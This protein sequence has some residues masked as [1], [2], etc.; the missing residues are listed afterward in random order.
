MDSNHHVASRSPPTKRSTQALSSSSKRLHSPTEISSEEPSSKKSK[1]A[2]DG[3]TSSSSNKQ[4]TRWTPSYWICENCGK[5]GH[6]KTECRGAYNPAAAELVAAEKKQIC[7][8]CGKRGHSWEVCRSAY[9]PAA[10]DI[11]A[12]EKSR[13]ERVRRR[14]EQARFLEA[15]HPPLPAQ[16]PAHP[17][18]VHRPQAPQDPA[19]NPVAA[20]VTKF[21][22]DPAV[23][24]SSCTN[25]FSLQPKRRAENVC[26]KMASRA[27]AQ[28]SSGVSSTGENDLDK[29][30]TAGTSGDFFLS[31]STHDAH[32]RVAGW[33]QKNDASTTCVQPADTGM[34]TCTQAASQPV[35]QSVP[36]SSNQVGKTRS[37]LIFPNQINKSQSEAA[38]YQI[39]KANNQHDDL[40]EQNKSLISRVIT[41]CETVHT[42]R[43]EKAALRSNFDAGNVLLEGIC[44]T[45]KQLEALLT[46]AQQA[47][48]AGQGLNALDNTGTHRH[49]AERDSDSKLSA[50]CAPS[51]D[52]ITESIGEKRDVDLD[53][54]DQL[55][56][57]Q[58]AQSHAFRPDSQQADDSDVQE[59][60]D[61]LRATSTTEAVDML[62]ATSTTSLCELHELPEDLRQECDCE[63]SDVCH[64]RGTKHLVD[65]SSGCQVAERCTNNQNA[66][67]QFGM[68][69]RVCLE[70]LHAIGAGKAAKKPNARKEAE[71]AP[72]AR[73]LCDSKL[74]DPKLCECENG[75]KSLLPSSGAS[76]QGCDGVELLTQARSGS[77]QQEHDVDVLYSAQPSTSMHALA[78]NKEQTHKNVQK[79]KEQST[80]HKS[81]TTVRECDITL[82]SRNDCHAGNEAHATDEG[83]NTK[84]MSTLRVF[85]HDYDGSRGLRQADMQHDGGQGRGQIRVHGESQQL[86]SL[87]QQLESLKNER[88]HE[89]SALCAEIRDTKSA[90]QK[91]LAD[92]DSEISEMRKLNRTMIDILKKKDST[93]AARDGEILVLQQ[94]LVDMQGQTEH[95]VGTRNTE[96]ATLQQT[97]EDLQNRHKREIS[98]KDDEIATL[99]QSV[100]HTGQHSEHAHAMVQKKKYYKNELR[101]VRTELQDL[102]DT[103]RGLEGEICAL[104]RERDGLKA[105]TLLQDRLAKFDEQLTRMQDDVIAKKSLEAEVCALN[106]ERDALK[107]KNSDLKGRL[108]ASVKACSTLTED[109]ARL[110]ARLQQ[111]F[112]HLDEFSNDLDTF[113]EQS[114]SQLTAKDAEI[115]ALKDELRSAEALS[116]S[117]VGEYES[118]LGLLENKSRQLGQDLAA[119]KRELEVVGGKYAQICGAFGEFRSSLGDLYA[120]VMTPTCVCMSALVYVYVYVYTYAYAY[121]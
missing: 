34:L 33:P 4:S 48:F 47:R 74:C 85:R 89:V 30:P 23:A 46:G 42:L 35:Q 73:S 111:V 110:E 36:I 54:G 3:N 116:R 121:A 98:Q 120:K 99:H 96:I 108:S 13:L 97:I 31:M 68:D 15:L 87:K 18:Q 66:C 95:Q 37:K 109:K 61:M 44:D 77:E 56:H 6:N 38:R 63:V 22:P 102:A 78:D 27:H 67:V 76:M 11:V 26:A 92:K 86:T 80:L 14:E 39:N 9:N 119:K 40:Q 105:D 62:R 25:S 17:A 88:V 52:R 100:T 2:V 71:C 106:K 59:A 29:D 8:N 32:M 51:T 53:Q 5:R 20:N 49:T 57:A 43:I 83:E 55:D 58:S 101:K 70:Q 118:K 64:V 84:C 50:D 1:R 65:E 115:Q 114:S 79:D 113:R 91:D 21:N 104:R 7:E 90:C 82:Q 10:A 41:L 112:V 24:R 19:Q 60:V 45:A 75:S 16:V 117:K 28:Q 94:T 69:A 93:L 107:Q 81:S 12:A 72:N 103:N